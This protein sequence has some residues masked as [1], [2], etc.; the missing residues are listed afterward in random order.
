MR[1]KRASIGC[2]EMDVKLRIWRT[3]VLVLIV[4]YNL[5]VAVADVCDGHIILTVYM[6]LFL[7][8]R[9]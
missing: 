5:C 1:T 9:R 2:R 4:C 8:Q 3:L 6:R 7:T